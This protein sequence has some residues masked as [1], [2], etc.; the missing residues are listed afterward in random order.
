MLSLH[1]A[2]GQSQR[3]I[4]LYAMFTLENDISVQKIM[5]Y[6]PKG[7]YYRSMVWKQE[8][9]EMMPPGRKGS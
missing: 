3:V 8:A 9:K 7:A 1:E 6:H 2:P 5:L 4:I